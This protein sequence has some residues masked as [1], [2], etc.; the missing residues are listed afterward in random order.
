MKQQI[1]GL[2]ES[3]RKL[4]RT[5]EKYVAPSFPSYE[6][7]NRISMSNTS[8]TNGDLQPQPLYGMPMN[9]Y[10]GQ[11]PPPPSL[12]GRSVTLDAVGP[13]ELL[14]GPSGPYADRSAFPAGQ[15]GP[16]PG[17]PH[18]VPI[19]ANA[20][21]QFGFTTGQAGYAYAEP[22]VAHHAPNYYTPQQQY[23]SP[24]TYLNHN[25]PYNHRPINTI[26]RSQQEGRYTNTRPNE[27][28]SR[29]SGGLPRV[30]WKKLGKR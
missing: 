17:L 8:A 24:S 13:S 9:S 10:T 21:G 25:V 16:A 19:M 29:G 11:V 1:V 15:S 4:T 7:S 27:P 26:D 2:E 18:G 22:F 3:I 30:Q 5:L 20:T 28:H 12:L 6:T 23:V 14:P